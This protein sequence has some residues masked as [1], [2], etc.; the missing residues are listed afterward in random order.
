MPKVFVFV[1]TVSSICP[2]KF[3]SAGILFLLMK[4]FVYVVLDGKVR[5][6]HQLLC[7]GHMLIT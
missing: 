4:L 3:A 5:H 1:I 2:E 6:V 7:D